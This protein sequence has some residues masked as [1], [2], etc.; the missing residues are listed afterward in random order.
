MTP[1]APDRALVAR[2]RA[3]LAGLGVGAEARLGLAVS[4]GP[5]SLAMLLLA[6]AGRLTI[7]AATVDHRLR[8]GSDREAVM[9]ARL[10]RKLGLPHETLAIEEAASGN[11]SA[12]ARR[13]RYAR[14]ERWADA[15]KLDMIVTAHHADDQLE[16]VIMRLNRGSGVAGLAGIRARNGRIVRPLLGWRRAELG[17]IVE[18]A[19]V[20]PVDDP[21]NRDDR[22][23]RA[24]LRKALAQADWLDP[25][26][27]AKSA[28]V[29]AEADAALDWAADVLARNRR[30]GEPYAFIGPHLP[31]EI[32]RRLAL[33][34]IAMIDPACQPDGKALSRF[35]TD[36]LDGRS[37]MIGNVFARATD[38]WWRF[39]PAPPRRPTR[40]RAQPAE[41]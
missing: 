41:C 22:Y 23:D 17:A 14:L 19:G 31:A 9:V 40:A 37:A 1:A 32:R 20:R 2:F 24:R 15:R 39:E 12:W 29:A 8:P 11:L 33:R 28:A 36:L 35:L 6:H 27:A 26:A 18:A 25:L 30:E 4:G 3:D 13:E 38:G 7:E 34:I 16:T 5:D 21:S 10:C